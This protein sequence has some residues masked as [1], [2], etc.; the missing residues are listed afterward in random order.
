MSAL[1]TNVFLLLHPLPIFQACFPAPSSPLLWPAHTDSPVVS[2][3]F[4]Q[5][6][7][8]LKMGNADSFS[9]C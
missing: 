7:D 5:L 4:T 1:P 6:A 3:I 8:P 9:K 2:V